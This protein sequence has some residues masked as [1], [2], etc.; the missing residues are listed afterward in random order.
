M[1]E[2]EFTCRNF[3]KKEAVRFTGYSVTL[4]TVL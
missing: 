2:R 4:I 3:T 1:P